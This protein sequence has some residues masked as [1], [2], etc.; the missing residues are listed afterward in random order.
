MKHR[1]A[2]EARAVADIDHSLF[3]REQLAASSPH[4]L[5][6][7]PG[8]RRQVRVLPE[9]VAE[10]GL[11]HAAS[12]SQRGR[13]DKARRL[14]AHARRQALAQRD[15]FVFAAIVEIGAAALAGAQTCRLG[16]VL[17][18]EQADVLGLRLPRRAGRQ[19]IDAGGEYPDQRS[20]A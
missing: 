11:A 7:E 18:S 1:F 6:T 9:Q 12:R 5:A 10:L 2:L 19:T 14:G 15:V 20:E 13:V 3:A 16:L 17:H 8:S 4:T